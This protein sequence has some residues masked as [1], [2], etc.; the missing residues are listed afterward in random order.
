MEVGRGFSLPGLYP[1]A[2]PL[3]HLPGPFL[4][5]VSHAI[6]PALRYSAPHPSC[7]CATTVKALHPLP[8]PGKDPSVYFHITLYHYLLQT[9]HCIIILHVLVCLSPVLTQSKML[10]I[11][12][13]VCPLYT[14]Y[15]PSPGT[16]EVILA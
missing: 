4:L 13:E 5:P 8:Q 15:S 12:P 7:M 16:K 14:S 6:T 3:C 1:P 9:Y 10:K 2:R 11:R